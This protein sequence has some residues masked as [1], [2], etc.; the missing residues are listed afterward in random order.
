MQCGSEKIMANY[1]KF[2]DSIELQPVAIKKETKDYYLNSSGSDNRPLIAKLAPTHAGI[3]TRNNGFY[4]PDKMRQGSLTFTQNYPKPILVHHDGDKDP[5]GRAIKA[6]YMDISGPVR[7]KWS[8]KS[9]KDS[10]G[11]EV[12]VFAKELFDQFNDGKLP[13]LQAVNLVTDV[14]LKDG[15]LDDPDYPGLGYIELVAGIVD[16][17]AK[18]KILDGRYLTGSTSASTDRAICSICKDD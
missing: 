7:D 16:P 10:V 1:V 5:I 11:R 17:D 14:L 9:L 4:L 8:G 15:L 6:N 2:I 12:G 3:V 13:Y 18:A